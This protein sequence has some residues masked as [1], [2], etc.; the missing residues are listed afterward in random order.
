MDGLKT[1]WMTL[2]ALAR[3]NSTS[4]PSELHILQHS[5]MSAFGSVTL[6]YKV[7]VFHS[8]FNISGIWSLLRLNEH[9]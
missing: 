1:E 5:Y 4:F 6:F 2:L 7:V 9:G 8:A 3:P